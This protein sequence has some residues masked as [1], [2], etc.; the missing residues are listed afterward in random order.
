MLGHKDIN[1]LTVH[2]STGM[3]VLQMTNLHALLRKTQERFVRYR[4]QHSVSLISEI[5][6]VPVAH[7][8]PPSLAKNIWKEVTNWHCWR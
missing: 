1:R 4:Q 7:R 8:T 6:K 2:R 3:H 5:D